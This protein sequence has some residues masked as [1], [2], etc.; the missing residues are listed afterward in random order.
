[1]ATATKPRTVTPVIASHVCHSR[2]IGDPNIGVD[3]GHFVNAL[4]EVITVADLSNRELLRGP[5]PGYVAAVEAVKDTHWGLDWIR[6]L[7]RE[8]GA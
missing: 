3:G 8:A 6:E 1:M 4:I 2:L 5:F 7:A